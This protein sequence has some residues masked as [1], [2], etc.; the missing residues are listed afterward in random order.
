[1]LVSIN[2]SAKL[3]YSEQNSAFNHGSMLVKLTDLHKIRL[4]ML[5]LKGQICPISNT[6]KDI[7]FKRILGIIVAQACF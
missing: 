2:M 5:I 7:I 3:N 1:M 4:G 6:S